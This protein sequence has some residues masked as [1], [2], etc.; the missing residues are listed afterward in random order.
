MCPSHLLFRCGMIRTVLGRDNQ[1]YT[2]Y[3]TKLLDWGSTELS[4][5]T[6][7]IVPLKSMVQLRKVKLVRKGT[8]LRVGNLHTIN[9]NNK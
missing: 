5:Q 8:M 9:H 1:Y 3:N 2:K 7:Y 4:A 6:G